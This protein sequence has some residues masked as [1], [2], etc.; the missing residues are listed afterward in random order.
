M[1]GETSCIE[2]GHA[3]EL[4]HPDAGDGGGPVCCRA[5]SF[6]GDACVLNCH[7]DRLHLRVETCTECGGFLPHD[8]GRPCNVCEEAGHGR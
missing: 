8:C 1:A 4:H 7:R 3:A 6:V 5:E 2:C